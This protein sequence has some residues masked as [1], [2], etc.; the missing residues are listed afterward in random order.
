MSSLKVYK[1]NETKVYGKIFCIDLPIQFF[2][3][4]NGTYDGFE[5]DVRDATEKEKELVKEFCDLF[6]DKQH[7]TIE[8]NKNES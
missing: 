6:P 2:F 8:E 5:I 4:T 7:Y 1:I 3:N